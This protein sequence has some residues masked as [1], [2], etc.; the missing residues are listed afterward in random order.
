MITLCKRSQIIRRLLRPIYV[1]QISYDYYRMYHEALTD[2][3]R[4]MLCAEYN[5]E[6]A[7]AFLLPFGKSA[8]GVAFLHYGL[9]TDA[10]FA[11]IF[12]IVVATLYLTGGQY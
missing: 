3:D 10:L 5:K 8:G 6:L 4:N 2:N 1:E 9:S 11:L 7:L 12:I